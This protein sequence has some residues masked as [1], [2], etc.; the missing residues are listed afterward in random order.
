MEK[1]M[2][3]RRLTVYVELEEVK[4]QS[5]LETGSKKQLKGLLMSEADEPCDECKRSGMC[6]GCENCQKIFC[7]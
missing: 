4:E 5:H 2:F 6:G 3:S 1:K 7:G